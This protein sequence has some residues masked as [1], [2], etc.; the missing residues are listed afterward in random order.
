MQ[1]L[2]FMILKI[3]RILD[4]NYFMS[5]IPALL[6]VYLNYTTHIRKRFFKSEKLC[7]NGIKFKMYIFEIILLNKWWIDFKYI[8]LRLIKIYLFLKDLNGFLVFN[9]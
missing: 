1:L 8:V 4:S 9:I 5:L 3:I 2:G 7:K 6:I